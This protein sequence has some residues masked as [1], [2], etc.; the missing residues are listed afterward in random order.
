M[1]QNAAD[2]I[3][4]HHIYQKFPKEELGGWGFTTM[5]SAV[6]HY[7]HVPLRQECYNFASV[8]DVEHTKNMFVKKKNNKKQTLLLSQNTQQTWQLRSKLLPHTPTNTCAHT[9]THM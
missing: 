5:L 4:L 1:S 7:Q 2:C 8:N 9:H 3:K 6:H